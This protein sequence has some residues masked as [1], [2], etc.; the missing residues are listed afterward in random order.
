VPLGVA[1]FSYSDT[2]NAIGYLSPIDLSGTLSREVFITM[3]NPLTAADVVLPQTVAAVVGRVRDAA[4][5][6][7]AVATHRVTDVYLG[8]VEPVWASDGGTGAA[9]K[10]FAGRG[11]LADKDITLQ[12]N[13][14]SGS[15][16]LLRYDVNVP[17]A[18][19]ANGMWLPQWKGGL[20]STAHA[21]AKSLGAASVAGTLY[22]YLVPGTDVKSGDRFEFLF[23]VGGIYA[24]R[25]INRK[26]PRTVAPWT[27]TVQDTVRQ[28]GGVTI[29]NNVISPRFQDVTTIVYTLRERGSVTI[30]VS[31]MEGNIVNVFQPGVQDP[32]DW[33]ATWDGR[34]RGGRAVAPGLYFVKITGPGFDEVRKVLVTN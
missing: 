34:N 16:A 27:F 3:A 21:G 6:F 14:G 23:E 32:G 11:R 26:D 12:A 24:A 7:M 1:D 13:N 20:V 19:K 30:L 33:S 5:N 25:V 15:A 28:R 9:L 8:L 29:M 17:A 31:D 4:S 10:D 18:D 2:G 22:T